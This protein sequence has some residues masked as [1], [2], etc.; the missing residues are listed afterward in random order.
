M[1]GFERSFLKKKKELV[2]F[3]YRKFIILKRR[4]RTVFNS[5]YISLLLYKDEKKNQF[6]KFIYKYYIR[7]WST[8]NLFS[9]NY[10][11]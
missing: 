8:I 11:N 5:F 3:E 7:I 4:T 10:S 6:H 9:F 2:I 1:Y